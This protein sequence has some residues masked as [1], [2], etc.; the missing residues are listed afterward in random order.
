MHGIPSSERTLAFLPADLTLGLHDAQV[1]HH[2]P[3]RRNVF[4]FARICF[5]RL[6]ASEHLRATAANIL[7]DSIEGWHVRG[8]WLL[9][10]APSRLS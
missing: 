2:R 3:V 7:D 6:A 4:H 10:E 1:Q 5:S 9:E 8:R